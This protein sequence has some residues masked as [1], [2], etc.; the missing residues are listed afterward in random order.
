MWPKGSYHQAHPHKDEGRRTSIRV[1]CS[2]L[3]VWYLVMST[4]LLTPVAHLPG[5]KGISVIDPPPAV[6]LSFA[7]RINKVEKKLSKV[8]RKRRDIDL[9]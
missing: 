4:T 1:F 9:V 7:G 5:T 3:K 6:R 2:S 8:K